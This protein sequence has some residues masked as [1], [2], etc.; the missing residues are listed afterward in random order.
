MAKWEKAGACNSQVVGESRCLQLQ[1]SRQSPQTRLLRTHPAK[2]LNQRLKQRCKAKAFTS[3][4]IVTFQATLNMLDMWTDSASDSTTSKAPDRLL[5]VGI[6]RDTKRDSQTAVMER[7]LFLI[8]NLVN[9]F[10]A[11]R[12]PCLYSTSSLFRRQWFRRWCFCSPLELAKPHGGSPSPVNAHLQ[13]WTSSKIKSRAV[14]PASG[15]QVWSYVLISNRYV[16]LIIHTF[17]ALP[18]FKLALATV[19]K[20]RARNDG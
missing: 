6:G 17:V 19:Y 13:S 9:F 15:V 7:Q 4:Q 11:G 16:C 1:K 8:A 20:N 5:S 14:W 10:L 3:P 18:L 12:T 2:W